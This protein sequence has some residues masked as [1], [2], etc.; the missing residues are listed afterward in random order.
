MATTVAP[1]ERYL[2][3]FDAF[4]RT[5][6]ARGPSWLGR[7]RRAAIARFTELG[8][9]TVRQEEWRYTNVAP[10]VEAALPPAVDPAAEG[11]EA[12]T[13]A[14]FA[15]GAPEW[16]RL[17][18]VNGHYSAK[19]SSVRPGAGGARITSLAETLVTDS[20]LLESHLGRYA[21]EEGD[22]FAALNTAFL[23]DG[24]VVYLPAGSRVPEPIHLRFIGAAPVLAQPR[25]LIV[26]EPASEAT[27]I[28]HY[29]G[30]GGGIY[31]SNVL[32]EIAA[33]DGAVIRHYKI[34]EE[35]S[36]AF[37]VG[38]TRVDQQ[39]DTTLWSCSAALGGRLVRNT[40]GVRLA[41]EG[42]TCTLDGLYL[43]GGHQ[44]VDNHITVDHVQPRC[45]SQQLY[46]GVLDGRSR[47]VFNGR[48]LVRP[49]AQKTD[50]NQTNKTLLLAEGPEVYSKPQLEIFAD[51][52]RCT[53]GAAEGQLAEEALFYLKSR[54]L[55]EPTAR[56][57]LTYGFA[58]EV[59]RRVTFEPV[60]AYLDQLLLA[61]LPEGQIGEAMP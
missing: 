45:A 52:V 14:P 56:A 40:L 16:N 59:I 15:L 32:T 50:A 27:I 19:L 60:R 18:F 35:S 58:S 21:G 43:V 34:E 11:V 36:Q 20:P 48:I 2:S 4:E 39:R 44:H 42:G 5:E 8:F 23:Q 12:D 46:K 61:R 55:R 7:L 57:L 26:A 3:A 29:V 10:I 22:G 51:D 1:T 25:T 54:G 41:A 53:H 17:V 49:D 24:A 9:P 37:H 31:C 47:A 13:I 33:A 38:T 28:E 30:F 6:A